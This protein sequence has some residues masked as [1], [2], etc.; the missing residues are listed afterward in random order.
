MKRP[1]LDRILNTQSS[2]NPVF[3]GKSLGIGTDAQRNCIS[4][5][6]PAGLSIAM[7]TQRLLA[8]MQ[9]SNE[10]GLSGVQLKDEYITPALEH[11]DNPK[12][13]F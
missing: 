3:K 1:D 5:I 10:L 4:N 13:L 9:R 6:R 2:F 12:H 8:L 11:R 7:T